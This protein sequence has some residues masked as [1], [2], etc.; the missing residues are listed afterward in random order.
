[1]SGCADN[2]CTVTIQW[3]YS[4]GAVDKTAEDVSTLTVKNRS[5]L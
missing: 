1:M 3:N 5:I 2:E 4:R